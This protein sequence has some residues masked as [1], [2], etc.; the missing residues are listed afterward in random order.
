MNNQRWKRLALLAA[1]LTALLLIAGYVYDL[2]IIGFSDYTYTKSDGE[3]EFQRGKTVWD[4]MQLLI[5]PAALAIGGFIFN[6]TEKQLEHQRAEERAA[7]E[8]KQA[9]ER[10][11]LEQRRVDERTQLE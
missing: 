11:Q 8:Q 10:T 7:R 4:W 9:E 1:L 2:A 6:R 3:S 5:V